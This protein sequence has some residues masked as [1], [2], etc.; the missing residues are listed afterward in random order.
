MIGFGIHARLR[1]IENAFCLVLARRTSRI[2][3]LK[4]ERSRIDKLVSK[5]WINLT[6][7]FRKN[8]PIFQ[9]NTKYIWTVATKDRKKTRQ[10]FKH[11]M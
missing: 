11:L 4:S 9:V 8:L 3:E 10:T 7:I 5:R 1:P 2:Y 6:F